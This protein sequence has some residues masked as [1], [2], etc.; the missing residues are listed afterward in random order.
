MVSTLKGLNSCDITLIV[1]LQG[2]PGIYHLTTQGSG[3]AAN[4]GLIYESPLGK[5][6]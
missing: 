5:E 3:K 4:P 1:L 2:T 6:T